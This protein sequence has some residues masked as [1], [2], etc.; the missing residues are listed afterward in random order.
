[1]KHQGNP[2]WSHALKKHYNLVII[3]WAISFFSFNVQPAVGQALSDLETST[4]VT[5]YL[6]SPTLDPVEVRQIMIFH[7]LWSEI[8]D[9]TPNEKAAIALQTYQL[10]AP[11]LYTKQTQP[12]LTAQ[13]Y[14]LQGLPQK[15]IK[16]LENLKDPHAT[17][18]KAQAYQTLG[19]YKLALKETQKFSIT[20]V[21]YDEI[22]PAKATYIG[23]LRMMRNVL[24]GRPGK[25]Y[26]DTLNH[27]TTVQND[28]DPMYWPA[29]QITAQLLQANGNAKAA[30]S[31]LK[32]TISLNL[33]NALAWYQYG[34]F[35]LHYYKFKE[36]QACI[37]KLNAIMP[38]HILAKLLHIQILI[39]KKDYAKGFQITAQILKK[40]PAHRQALILKAALYA[41]LD[42]P[43]NLE[44]TLGQYHKLSPQNA[45]IYN[46]IGTLLSKA[47][48]YDQSEKFL[49]QAIKLQ[50]N[51][52]SPHVA[53]GLMLM[54]KGDE[55]QA[56]LQLKIA[57][58]LNPFNPSVTNQLNLM[59]SLKDFTVISTEH[60]DIKYKPGIDEVL[61]IDIS[62]HIEG[63]YD[64]VTKRFKYQPKNRTTIEI[65]PDHKKFAIRITG[66]NEIGAFAACTGDIIAIDPPRISAK[67]MTL[68]N[69]HD[70]LTH[71]FAHTVTLNMTQFKTP[72]WFTEA[73]AVSVEPNNGYFQ[74]RC[75]LLV[76]KYNADELF[77]LEQISWAFITPKK[78]EDRGQAYAQGNWFVQY[79]TQT[80]G[81]DAIIK[82]NQLYAKGY[83]NTQGI[84]AITNLEPEA[85]M[86]HF[87]K[88]AAKEIKRW[89]LSTKDDADIIDTLSNEEISPTPEALAKL[90]KQYMNNATVVRYFIDQDIARDNLSGLEKHLKRLAQLRPYGLWA[91]HQL[92]LIAEKKQDMSL[93]LS[94]LAALN[95]LDRQTDTW[96]DQLSKMY[97]QLKDAPNTKK[98]AMAFIT[99]NPY[100]PAARE[101][102]A[103]AC[104]RLKEVEQARLHLKALSILEPDRWQNFQRLAAISK[105]L[106][107]HKEAQ[108]A[109]KQALLLNPKAPV[110]KY[111]N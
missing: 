28:I 13:A 38:K 41:L 10:D 8:P 71:E 111:M 16:L 15:A 18:L 73:C 49:Q 60:F 50:P 29:T 101:R 57:Q 85:F 33:K 65:M 72:H 83:T 86:T 20:D 96:A 69:W 100:N 91:H 54:Q 19:Q 58:K 61:A 7:G 89:G 47:R 88:W 52:S 35:S 78:A 62:L 105:M 34:Q 94:T 44:K 80:Y 110:Q 103:T 11:Q 63:I 97:E 64:H 104:L 37:D 27:F 51:W 74:K 95:R 84:K 43:Q 108:A 42:Q 23:Q 24:E 109:A 79:I 77:T 87:K 82:L 12:Q 90:K 98:Y 17:L 70:T 46:T 75:N 48:Y 14:L 76:S 99:R 36:T 55:K 9:L 21:D 31:Q 39:A 93:L 81:Q 106:K 53:L 30:A 66:S 6:E 67:N 68:Y 4:R 2:L 102:I 40:Y 45:E 3:L 92:L 5:K 26:Q 59:A 1:M 56:M 22:S 25:D 107:R 32:K